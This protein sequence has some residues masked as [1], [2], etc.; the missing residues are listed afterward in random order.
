MRFLGKIFMF[1]KSEIVAFSSF[2]Y[3]YEL[4][5]GKRAQENE[6]NLKAVKDAPIKFIST[7]HKELDFLLF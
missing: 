7:K 3:T 5:G 2:Y 1:T 4:L 6:A